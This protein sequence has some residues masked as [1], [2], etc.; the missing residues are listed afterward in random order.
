MSKRKFEGESEMEEF[1]SKKRRPTFGA[2]MAEYYKDLPKW[3]ASL[4][5]LDA[6][7]LFSAW[8]NRFIKTLTK[9]EKQSLVLGANAAK[10]Q[11]EKWT[12]I[13]ATANELT[14][15]ELEYKLK[16]AKLL[17]GMSSRV[18][19]DA[20][21]VAG[22]ESSTPPST[23]YDASANKVKQSANIKQ[24]ANTTDLERKLHEIV[25]NCF[26]GN[27]IS[28]TEE[29]VL[30]AV[31]SLES[32]SDCS[33]A[34]LKLAARHLLK[35]EKTPLR[36]AI[37]KLS[38]SRI[39]NLVDT[40]FLSIYQNNTP[41]VVWDNIQTEARR[42]EAREED[43]FPVS[44]MTLFNQVVQ[45]P[46]A[47]AML[48]R[49]DKEKYI[50]SKC[51]KKD[52]GEYT[53]L[54]ILEQVARNFGRHRHSDSEATSYRRFASLLDILLDETGI[55]MVDGENS[56]VATKINHGVNN[57]FF[58]FKLSQ[59]GRKIDLILRTVENTEICANEFMKETTD[60]A[61]ILM[62]QSK[63]LCTNAGL[64]RH[65]LYPLD[66][67]LDKTVAIDFIGTTGYIYVLRLV[68]DDFFIAKPV[69]PLIYPKEPQ[70]FHLFQDTLKG[71]FFFKYTLQTT[72]K[73][74]KKALYQRKASVALPTLNASAP[75]A[76]TA[77]TRTSTSLSSPLIY[78][79]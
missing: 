24:S 58:D 28:K 51:D 4:T 11:K 75:S 18:Y 50:L 66:H 73:S 34:L 26:S 22:V 45:E 31:T 53:I 48:K 3:S 37:I 62:Q 12:T 2:F 29:E 55:T 46:S 52:T 59:Y 65:V 63:N 30:R 61:L 42:M 13:L 43:Y 25:Y 27:P 14:G 56:P 68:N 5:H 33:L 76:S 20:S 47:K 41:Q 32:D 9:F 69:S 35:P 23:S 77:A 71:L 36:D 49:I 17:R 57:A 38:L 54:L 74:A 72:A 78:T 44:G 70:N 8:K 40:R 21:A 60:D 6:A 7:N 10:F 79:S 67:Q 16:G 1:V 19:D 39:Y 64:L 15:I